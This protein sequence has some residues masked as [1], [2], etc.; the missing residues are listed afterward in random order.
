MTI[1]GDITGFT[2]ITPAMV[3]ETM[4]GMIIIIVMFARRARIMPLRVRTM[5]MVETV[6]LIVIRFPVS[7][8]PI[9]VVTQPAARL[10]H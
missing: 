8:C 4:A 2:I 3:T 9:A 1:S 6:M 5:P 7:M 10:Q